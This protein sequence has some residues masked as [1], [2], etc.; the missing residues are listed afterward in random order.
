MFPPF[1]NDRSD[2]DVVFSQDARDFGQDTRLVNGGKAEVVVGFNV[3]KGHQ[4]D[5]F[6]NLFPQRSR[7][8]ASG[9]ALQKLS[10]NIND[11]AH[12]GTG[13][14]HHARSLAIKKNRTCCVTSDVK[15]VEIAVDAGQKMIKGNHRGMQP[16]FNRFLMADC[17]GQQL[18]P[19]SKLL[20]KFNVLL[21]DVRDPFTVKIVQVHLFTIGQ[22]QGNG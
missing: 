11:I 14:G 15:G 2:A 20:R 5:I 4:M 13:C 12:H 17:N 18:D 21:A 22:R 10:G 6:N 19:V 1:L 3:V 16:G 9:Y 7:G 8:D